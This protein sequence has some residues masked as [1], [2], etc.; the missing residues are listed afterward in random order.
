MSMK[1]LVGNVSYVELGL[2]VLF[3]ILEMPD[4]NPQ[5]VS[6]LARRNNSKAPEFGAGVGAGLQLSMAGIANVGSGSAH[7]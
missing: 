7:G 1:M 6:S 4:R 2:V 5:T 3:D